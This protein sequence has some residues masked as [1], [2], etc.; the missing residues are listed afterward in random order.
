MSRPFVSA[1]LAG[2]TLLGGGAA[3][4][5]AAAGSSL[6]EVTV[7]GNPLGSADM[8]A[9][10]AETSG[11]GLL[12][13]RQGSLGETLSGL[14]GVSSTYYGPVASRPVIRGQD[15]DRVRIL[16]NSGALLDASALS[17]DHAVALDP[18]AVER[19][20][21]LRGPGALLYGGNAIGGVVNMID[22]RIPREPL[23]GVV[24]R[25]DLGVASGNHERSG[26]ALVEGGSERFA[27]HVDG[28]DRR[29]G[30]TRVP[31]GLAC[32]TGGVATVARQL[33]NSDADASGGA[34]GGTAFFDQGYLGASYSSNRSDYGSVAQD[35]VRLRMRSE[36][37]AIEGL[38]RGL[39]PWI[40]SLKLQA[41]SSRYQHTEFESEVPGTTFRNRGTDLRLEARHAPLGAWRGVVG[42]Q[43]DGAHF[44]AQ[45]DEA[46]V[47]PSE[48]RQR[49]LFVYEE[50]PTSWGQV[51][52]G[53]RREW[54]TVESTGD[55]ANPRF[56]PARRSFGPA[57]LSLGSLWKLTPAWQLT[58]NLSR[59]Q[60]A[61]RDYELFA[62]GPHVAT[63]SF[64]R[65]DATV[66]T[67][68]A[69]SLDAG[70]QWKAGHDRFKL[71]AFQTRYA[72]Y[73]ALLATGR[74]RDAAGNGAGGGVTD[75]GNGTSVESGCT[76]AVLPE[77]AY[78]GVSA[79][80]RGLEAD[81]SVRLWQDAST[82]DL[83][84]RG[85]LVRADNLTLGEPLPRIAPLHAG[86]TLAWATG[87]WGAR[88]GAD[89]YARQ[90]R[91]PAGDR[92]VAGYTTVHAAATYKAKAGP[93][94]L[95]WY[96]RLDNL[97]DHLG[98]SATSI[99]TQSAPGRVPLPGRSLRLGL[100]ADF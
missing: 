52:V 64:E 36:R 7:T 40:E 74:T 53:A 87:P 25:A 38:V 27:L 12:L 8:A 90:D 11:T 30:D 4:A 2:T 9:P 34:V 82:L 49:A 61:P 75:C 26:A 1:V 6:T 22:N 33:C 16:E 89:A 17:F 56:A 97:T 29:S 88:L 71:S 57:S 10:V 19:I 65:G 94:G 96:A 85:D 31:I 15:G 72:N 59:S 77:F 32:N 45:G 55:P 47:P 91:V 42:L 3:L 80:F 67:E 5:Q 98:Y 83:E 24:G 58:G 21:V 39:G 28:F 86:A 54:V 46:F 37:A 78:R 81:G 99:L 68:Q 43:A 69:T 62:N 20:E 35:D 51:S 44:Q 93:A 66:G 79:R 84:W 50:L 73:L 76:S 48:T 13:R 14:P 18:I 95:L 70:V 23:P 63:G 60:R 41:S 100:R 92:A